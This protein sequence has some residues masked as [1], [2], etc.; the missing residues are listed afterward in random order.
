MVN[1]L[2]W[3]EQSPKEVEELVVKLAREGV[4]PS[5]IGIILRDQHGIPSVKRVTG[6]DMAEILR[7]HGIR[8]KVPEDLLNV[9]RSAVGLYGHLDRGPKDFTAKRALERIESRVHK[10]V[11]YYKRRGLLPPDWR[12]DRRRAALL[13]RE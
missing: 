6:K 13:V 7:V 1:S 4:P 9:I 5:K 3:I 11:K 12:Y 8:P 2:K 10:I